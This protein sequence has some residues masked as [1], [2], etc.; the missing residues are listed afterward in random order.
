MRIVIAFSRYPH[1]GAEH[2]YHCLASES[3][4][5]ALS[6]KTPQGSVFFPFLRGGEPINAA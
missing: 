1:F 4:E 5:G 2:T 6:N 3:P